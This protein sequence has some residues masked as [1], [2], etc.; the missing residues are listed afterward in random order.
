LSDD[1]PVLLSWGEGKRETNLRKHGYDF[2][3]LAPAFD[4]RFCIVAEDRRR[5][6]G[7]GRY[8]MLVQFDRRIINITFTPRGERHHL[9][10]ARPASRDERTIYHDF[11]QR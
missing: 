8:N 6:Y 9:I 7:E 10:S 3:D 11:A 1:E 5:D 2:A 4:G